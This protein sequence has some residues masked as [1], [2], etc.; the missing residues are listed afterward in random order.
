MQTIDATDFQLDAADDDN[1]SFYSVPEDGE[2]VHDD[3][4]PDMPG[5]LAKDPILGEAASSTPGTSNAAHHQQQPLS[6][7][8]DSR[9]EAPPITEIKGRKSFPSYDEK[10][11]VE[12]ME[13]ELTLTEEEA[14][15]SSLLRHNV[16]GLEPVC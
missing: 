11:E 16:F 8:D 2:D 10:I 5:R 9:W 12:Q 4:S 1:E 15:V 13:A 3:Q 14:A 7:T 6:S